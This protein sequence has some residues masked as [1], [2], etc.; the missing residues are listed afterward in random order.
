MLQQL[1]VQKRLWPCE[2]QDPIYAMNQHMNIYDKYIYIYIYM[3]MILI[4]F[5]LFFVFITLWK[6]HRVFRNFF[7]FSCLARLRFKGFFPQMMTWELQELVEP[8]DGKPHDVKMSRCPQ[9][10]PRAN[11]RST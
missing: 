9:Q 8:I 11:P 5:S 10:K 4:S 2:K 6:L 7:T 1:G 3:G